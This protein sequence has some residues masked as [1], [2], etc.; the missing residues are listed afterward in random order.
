MTLVATGKAYDFLWPCNVALE[1][2]KGKRQELTASEE[3]LR[4]GGASGAIQGL[5][6]NLSDCGTEPRQI[7]FGLRLSF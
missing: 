7:E 1:K 4:F 5:L 2:G 6:K 3:A